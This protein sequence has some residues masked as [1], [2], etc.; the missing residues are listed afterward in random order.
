[1][2]RL[3]LRSPFRLNAGKQNAWWETG[4]DHEHRLFQISCF[5][6]RKAL[7]FYVVEPI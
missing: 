5:E 4:V 6:T 2:A 1:M 7:S 3:R